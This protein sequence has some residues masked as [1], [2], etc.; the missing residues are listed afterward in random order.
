MVV[1]G[2]GGACTNT[3]RVC[4]VDE[5]LRFFGLGTGLLML[6][7]AISKITDYKLKLE[8]KVIRC[9]ANWFS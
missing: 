4:I 5:V 1:G 6:A 8:V 2:G 3:V 7:Y 9:Y